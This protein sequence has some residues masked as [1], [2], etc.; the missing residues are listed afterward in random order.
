[1]DLGKP[2]LHWVGLVD[3]L[4]KFAALT[5]TGKLLA[6]SGI[7]AG[8]WFGEGTLMRRDVW[9]YEARAL[10]P[11]ELALLPRDTFLWLLDRNLA[12]NRFI[13]GQLNDRLELM[14]LH[15]LDD[16]PGGSDALVARTLRHLFHPLA[17]HSGGVLQITQQEI[18]QFCGLSRQRVN[19]ALQRL[20]RD[21]VIG[22]RYGGVEVRDVRLLR[23]WRPNPGPANAST[24]RLSDNGSHAPQA[25]LPKLVKSRREAA[26]SSAAGAARSD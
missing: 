22:L 11:C 2:A 8:A 3:G 20:E 19:Q 23:N 1:M 26:A 5:A 9:R 15:A 24:P 21:G 4:A 13:L 14:T 25:A 6:Y 10:R 18:G 12:F 16:G 17:G 7:G